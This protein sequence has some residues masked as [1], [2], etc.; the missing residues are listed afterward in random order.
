MK[1]YLCYRT[2][3]GTIVENLSIHST[4]EA[5][6]DANVKHKQSWRKFEDERLTNGWGH[7]TDDEKYMTWAI[8]EFDLDEPTFRSLSK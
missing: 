3:V 7:K 8:E 1:A 5:A 2:F 4:L 6:E